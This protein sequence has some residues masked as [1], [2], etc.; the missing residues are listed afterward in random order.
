VTESG[1]PAARSRGVRLLRAEPEV[2]VFSVESGSYAF[3]AQR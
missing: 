3:A 2:A 1:K